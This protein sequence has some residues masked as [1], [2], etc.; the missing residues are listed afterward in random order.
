[1]ETA[2]ARLARDASARGYLCH[3]MEECLQAVVLVGGEGTRLRPLTYGTPK[4]MVPICGVPFLERTLSRLKEA[5]ID[6]A[7]LAAGYLPEA[8]REHF[9]DGGRLG[10]RITYVVEEQPLGTA[11]ALKNVERHIRGPFFVLNGDVL[12]NLDLTAM[13][14]SHRKAGGVGT[15]HLIRV[16]DPSAFG[17][18][19]HDASGRVSAF[20]EK[21]PRETAPTDEINAGT[22]LLE[23]EVLD[24]IPA[25]RMVSIER[26]TFPELIA[27]GRPLYAYT[28]DDYWLDIGRPE[29]YLRAHR[30][31]LDGVCRLAPLADP[32]MHRGRIWRVGDAGIPAGVE[33]PVFLADDVEIAPGARVGPYAVLGE[34]VRVATEATVAVSVVWTGAVIERRATVMGSVLADNV[35]IGSG[36]YVH[37][38]TVVGHDAEIPAETSVPP[39]SRIVAEPAVAPT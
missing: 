33:A 24:A 1:M 28:T 25:G 35:R 15:L 16:E 19:V 30:D 14:A 8:I 39:H 29:H 34:R 20:V 37:D 11:G 21:P 5:G 7:I 2:A 23:R 3:Y 13:L 38:G 4:P 12:T 17:C 10:M 26:E 9:G 27:A 22:Y 36:A 31:V 6:E 32:E 18:V